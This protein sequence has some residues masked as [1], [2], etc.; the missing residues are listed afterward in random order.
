[1]QIP[2]TTLTTSTQLQNN[3]AE[4]TQTSS[5]SGA[6][7]DYTAFLRLLIAQMKNQDPTN[8][9]DPSEWMG[10]IASFSNVEQA[11]QTNAKLDSL[12]TSMALSQVDGLIGR[13]ITSDD[14]S[15][16]GKIESVR[17][18]S[19]GTVAVLDNGDQVMLGSGLKI[20]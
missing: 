8:P 17:I 9:T 20:S 12:M 4:A 7:L 10:Q 1:M 2:S 18:V 13:T 3:T 6:S 19:G 14:G 11:I 15:V 5:T 16:S